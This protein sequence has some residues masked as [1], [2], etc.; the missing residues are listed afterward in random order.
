MTPGNCEQTMLSIPTSTLEVVAYSM[1]IFDLH[2]V[3][4]CKNNKHKQYV[5]HETNNDDNDLI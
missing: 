3:S 2:N 4:T 1:K 5:H